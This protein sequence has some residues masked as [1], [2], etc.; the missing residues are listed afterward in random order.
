MGL[1]VDRAFIDAAT[2]A[3]ALREMIR[4]ALIEALFTRNDRV[5]PKEIVA[6]LSREP[7]VTVKAKSDLEVQ[8]VVRVA[9]GS[10]STVT[11]GLPSEE[12]HYMRRQLSITKDR[13]I[14]VYVR[15]RVVTTHPWIVPPQGGIQVDVRDLS[16]IEVDPK[17]HRAL[18]GVGATWKALYD[19]AARAG[20]L[21]PFSPLLPLDYALGDAL[22]GDAVF[23]SYAAPFRRYLYGVRSFASHGRRTRVGF[24]EVPNHGAGYD[25]LGLLQNTMSEFVVPVAMGVALAPRPSVMKNW[26][27]QFPDAAKLG[28]ALGKLTASG[29]SCLYANVYDAAAWALLHPGATPAPFVLELGLAGA[30][31]VVAAREKALDT[32]LAG[33]TSKTPDT[34]SSYD[35]EARAYTRTA[36]RISRLLV[37][38]YVTTPLVSLADITAKLKEVSEASTA[39]LA[40]FGAVRRTGTVSLAPAFDAPKEAA[41]MYAIS[42][43]VSSKVEGIPGASYLSRLAQLWADDRMYRARLV[44]LR[45]LKEDID[46]A[47]VVEPTVVP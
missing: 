46:S 41:R 12:Y 14:G 9:N 21:V 26:T 47:R 15:P 17:G 25:A 29:R 20:R 19:E 1:L 28:A 6:V 4:E 34:P 43:Q 32:V 44:V 37:P 30:P 40:L 8:K 31:S 7:S 36:E 27:Y 16:T 2:A 22:I 3:P 23:T 38:G 13:D 5:L 11:L 18:V 24:D 10:E 35:A 45:K 42:R 33:F 39:G